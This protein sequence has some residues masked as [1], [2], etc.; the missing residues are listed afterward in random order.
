MNEEKY[1][2]TKNAILI[3]LQARECFCFRKNIIADLVLIGLKKT[4]IEQTL[5]R[6]RKEKEIQKGQR[7]WGLM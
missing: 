4:N 1:K 7:R 5:K 3:Y 6:M 2:E